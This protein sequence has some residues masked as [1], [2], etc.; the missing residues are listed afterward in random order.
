M[1]YLKFFPFK[2]ILFHYFNN[3]TSLQM[4][5]QAVVQALE[6]IQCPTSS[7]EAR[8]QAEKVHKNTQKN[9]EWK[10]ITN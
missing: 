2:I 9:N 1:P 8:K 6:I 10:Q 5:V 3:N 7:P 4:N